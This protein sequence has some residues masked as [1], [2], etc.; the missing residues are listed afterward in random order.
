FLDDATLEAVKKQRD[1]LKGAF[2]LLSK[3]VPVLP[4][5]QPADSAFDSLLPPGS[6]GPQPASVHPPQTY[7]DRWVLNAAIAAT[8]AIGILT[9]SGKPDRLFNM[10]GTGPCC[11]PSALPLAFITHEDY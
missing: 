9:D 3:D 1:K 4:A 8:G 7:A 6:T 11:D 2:V 10:G 5:G